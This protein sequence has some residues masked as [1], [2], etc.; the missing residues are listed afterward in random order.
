MIG[1]GIGGLAGL[2]ALFWNRRLLMWALYSLAIIVFSY[3]SWQG[4]FK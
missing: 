1:L 4:F 3:G 2:G